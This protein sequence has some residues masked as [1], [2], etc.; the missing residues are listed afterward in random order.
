[1][2]RRYRSVHTALRSLAWGCM[3]TPYNYNRNKLTA[4]RWRL[5][6]SRVLTLKEN[7]TT[8][9]TTSKTPYNVSRSLWT[10]LSAVRLKVTDAHYNFS[11]TKKGVHFTIKKRCLL[12]FFG[13]TVFF[14]N[15]NIPRVFPLNGFFPKSNRSR[16]ET[17]KDENV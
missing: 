10:L 4:R 5:G 12:I 9:S 13:L 16:N 6:E 11:F 17:S 14:P 8:S 2:C 7:Q 1:M 3:R 15:R